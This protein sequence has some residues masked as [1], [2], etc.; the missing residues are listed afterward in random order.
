MDEKNREVE[1]SFDGDSIKIKKVLSIDEYIKKNALHTLLKLE[2][3]NRQDLCT[4]I[5]VDYT[6]E[7]VQIQNHTKET[8]L[9][10]FGIT[11]HPNWENYLEFLESRCIPKTRVGLQEYLNSLEIDEYDPL[12]IIQKTKGKMAED[13][14]WLKVTKL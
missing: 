11:E 3:Y 13:H 7:K 14:Q 10:A 12:E 6:D 2:Y 4:T 5:L 9:T 8:I 1:L